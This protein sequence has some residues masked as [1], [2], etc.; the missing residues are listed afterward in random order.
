MLF[1]KSIVHKKHIRMIMNN[2]DENDSK[3]KK[4]MTMMITSDIDND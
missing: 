1:V 3:E 4:K 2:G